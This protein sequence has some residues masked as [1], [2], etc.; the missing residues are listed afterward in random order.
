MDRIEIPED[1]VVSLDNIAPAVQGL[2]ITF[3]NVLVL[4]TAM[5]RG[6]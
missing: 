5:V 6:L 1:Q 4:Q 3:V 2:R